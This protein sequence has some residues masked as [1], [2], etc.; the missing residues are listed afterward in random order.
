MI[1]IEDIKQ[2]FSLLHRPR[3]MYMWPNSRISV[4]G[5]EQAA[6]V[7]AQITREQ[8]RREGKEVCLWCR[9]LSCYSYF[10]YFFG[11]DL[12]LVYEVYLSVISGKS[13][14]GMYCEF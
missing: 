5:G 6:G 8:R 4:M 14:L 7:L 13:Y 2:V 1:M 11:K 10:R 3:F 9:C 12:L